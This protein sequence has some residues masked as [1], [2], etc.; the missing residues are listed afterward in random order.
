VSAQ[1]RK[2]VVAF[3]LLACLAVAVV[4]VRAAEASRGG[5]LAAAVG[6]VV[7]VHGTLPGQSEADRRNAG[8]RVE[9]LGPAF[10]AL[11]GDAATVP[12]ISDPGAAISVGAGSSA[13]S[14][15]RGTDTDSRNSAKRDRARPE[16]ARPES[17]RPESA[18][19]DSDRSTGDRVRRD[20]AVRDPARDASRASRRP[21][22]GATS[23]PGRAT[24]K[25][26]VTSGASSHGATKKAS[27]RRRAA[28]HHV[29]GRPPHGRS[30]HWLE[31]RRDDTA[32][33][34]RPAHHRR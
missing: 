29:R 22:P 19:P 3:V 16:S 18:K 8:E 14:A 25:H 13:T 27:H 4:G 11:N 34:S 9:V 5:F 31:S 28:G 1:H 20:G 24:V 30:P 7:Q 10:A 32:D 33:A 2:P 15:A 6:V 21:A 23:A 26:R 12:I 17:A